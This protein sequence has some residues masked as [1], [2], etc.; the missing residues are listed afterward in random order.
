MRKLIALLIV[1]AV[2]LGLAA[3]TS[4]HTTGATHINPGSTSPPIAVTAVL[5]A[6]GSCDAP[7]GSSGFCNWF[8]E[9]STGAAAIQGTPPAGAKM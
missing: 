7:A 2:A 4:G 5:N 6:T 1:L 9:Y 3:C 8:F